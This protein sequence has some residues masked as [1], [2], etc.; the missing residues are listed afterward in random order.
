MLGSLARR[1]SLAGI[2]LAVA[3]CASGPK[4]VAMAP[5]VQQVTGELPVPGPADFSVPTQQFYVGPG[6]KL[7]IDV[8]G[9][10]ELARDV[11][12]DGAG[13]LSFPLAGVIDAAGRTPSSIAR[14]IEARL[15][16]EYVKNPQVTVNLAESLN[17]TLTVDGEVEKPGI[18]PV[19]GHMTLARAVALAG[20]TSELAELDDVLIQREV[21]DDTYLGIYNLEAIRRGNYRDPEVYPADL[22]IVGDSQRRRL[23]R[24]LLQVIPLA[25][26]PLILLLQR[27]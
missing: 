4:P 6:D 17:Q 12:V 27:N 11:Q 7:N 2:A 24:D 3:A 22:I 26:T 1:V 16:G 23:F 25:T 8:F 14:E 19:V 5:S 20:G 18:Y 21:G 9:V 15:R 10:P 13:E